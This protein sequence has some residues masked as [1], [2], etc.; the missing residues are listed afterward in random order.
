M[1]G[2]GM[3]DGL[4]TGLILFGMVLGVAF[5]G[6]AW[7]AYYLWCHIDIVWLP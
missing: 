4:L 1:V 3:F 7:L 6:L 5:C 2:P